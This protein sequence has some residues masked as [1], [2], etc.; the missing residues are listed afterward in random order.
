MGRSFTGNGFTK[1]GD[2]VVP[3]YIAK[4]FTMRKGAEM[5]EVLDDGTQPLVPVLRGGSWIPQG[6]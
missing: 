1:A 5:W 4:D 2:D 6:N 3:E